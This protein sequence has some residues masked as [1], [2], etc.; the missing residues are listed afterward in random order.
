ME[1]MSQV[2]DY[3]RV[4]GYTCKPS[5]ARRWPPAKDYHHDELRRQRRGKWWRQIIAIPGDN[6]CPIDPDFQFA[7][8]EHGYSLG[9]RFDNDD[10]EWYKCWLAQHAVGYSLN[11]A[12]NFLL[13]YLHGQHLRKHGVRC[14][15]DL[16]SLPPVAVPKVMRSFSEL[17]QVMRRVRRQPRPL[18]IRDVSAISE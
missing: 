16:T 17:N 3:G 12:N 1:A 11:T 10:A 4:Y 14:R 18:V 8:Y 2:L 15:A 5:Y 7:E 9:L 6:D 13:G